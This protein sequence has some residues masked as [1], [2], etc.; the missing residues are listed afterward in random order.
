MDSVKSYKKKVPKL[1][2]RRVCG[3]S[4]RKECFDKLQNQ[5]RKYIIFYSAHLI[6]VQRD[7][8]FFG[9]HLC[10]FLTICGQVVSALVA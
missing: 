9:Q 10:R 3:A 5:Y 6:Q 2:S 7:H 1:T 4:N 8:L